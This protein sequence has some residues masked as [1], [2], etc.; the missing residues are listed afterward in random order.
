MDTTGLAAHNTH[1]ALNY[2]A[3]FSPIDVTNP[4]TLRA[5]ALT[6]STQPIRVASNILVSKELPESIGENNVSQEGKYV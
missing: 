3:P 5:I 6:Y 2:L 4:P 1:I